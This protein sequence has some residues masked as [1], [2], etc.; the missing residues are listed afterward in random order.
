MESEST[1]EIDGVF[2]C[3]VELK[4]LPSS[5]LPAFSVSAFGTAEEVKRADGFDLVSTLGATSVADFTGTALE[6]LESEAD[7]LAAGDGATQLDDSLAP[8]ELADTGAAGVAGAAGDGVTD[9]EAEDNGDGGEKGNDS[10]DAAA[11]DEKAEADGGVDGKDGL[12]AAGEAKEIP[13]HF[14]FC[15][16][17]TVVRRP[18]KNEDRLVSAWSNREAHE[19]KC[20]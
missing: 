1:N 16:S 8:I 19:S 17:L 12:L 9:D 5:F 20:H 15:S 13:L 18:K 11:D 6:S 3:D 4:N 10:S 14:E 7:F 2:G